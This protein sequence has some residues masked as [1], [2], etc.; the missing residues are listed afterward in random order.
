[1]GDQ[2]TA[3]VALELVDHEA[4]VLETYLDNANPPRWTWGIGVTD[5]SGHKV[6]RYK[7]NPST[8]EHVLEVYIWLLRKNY[9]PGVLR[10]FDG[11]PLSET[12]FAAAL[13]FHYNTGA[14]GT[15]S[16]VG[17]VKSGQRDAARKFL[18]THYLND[19]ALQERRDKEAKLFFDGVW[20]QRDTA[21]VVPVNRST[22]KPM[23]G[24]AKRVDIRADMDK[25]LAA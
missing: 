9:I 19:G 12:E 23:F 11:F 14:I 13:S 18:T 20:S 4:I 5:Q 10:A 24:K 8:I 3:R 25:A 16:W 2:L 15:T 7:A 6:A 17:M 1:M 22:F 21:M